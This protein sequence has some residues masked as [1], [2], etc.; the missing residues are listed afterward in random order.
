[1]HA[2]PQS[3][4]ASARERSVETLIVVAPRSSAL[5]RWRRSCT[6]AGRT[7]SARAPVADRPPPASAP[8]VAST[9]RSPTRYER[10]R[11]RGRAGTSARQCST[12]A[13]P[14]AARRRPRWRA[15]AR[16][17]P[18]RRA[19]RGRATPRRRGRARAAAISS[20]SWSVSI[21]TPEPCETRRT[22]TP[23]A[24]GLVE[25]C[26]HHDRSF[27]GRD[28]DPVAE[29]VREAQVAHQAQNRSNA[30]GSLGRA[31]TCG[32]ARPRSGRAAPGRGRARTL[33]SPLAR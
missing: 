2:A 29:A 24:V 22:G 8:S 28:L 18:R 23:R 25:H 32:R 13:S 16:P 6:G 5:A 17:C 3:R 21:I 9:P 10:I 31:S 12:P 1:M 19:G 26:P 30:A 4:R 33:R 7:S 20:S 15:T 27:D 11:G 14:R